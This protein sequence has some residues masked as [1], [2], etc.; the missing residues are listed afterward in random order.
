MPIVAV[1]E[2]KSSNRFQLFWKGF[3]PGKDGEFTGFFRREFIEFLSSRGE[4]H[5]PPP[6]NYGKIP[7]SSRYKGLFLTGDD[8]IVR[9]F[10]RDTARSVRR[11]NPRCE[12]GVQ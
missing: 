4:K 6:P 9:D 5:L 8:F 11:F 2:K 1:P 7:V 12:P 10:D 3:P